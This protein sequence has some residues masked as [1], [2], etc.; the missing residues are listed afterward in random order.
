M[1]N[2]QIADDNLKLRFDEWRSAT[3]DL[4][5]EYSNKPISTIPDSMKAWKKQ[6]CDMNFD[7]TDWLNRYIRKSQIWDE[8]V[9]AT[10]IISMITNSDK[11]P[12]PREMQQLKIAMA[13]WAIQNKYEYK[14]RHVYPVEDGSRKETKSVIMNAIIHDVGED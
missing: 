14:S 1:N 13:E 11:T 6:V 10:Q 12:H 9:S 4:L 3:L 7:Y 2:I 8:F 5:I